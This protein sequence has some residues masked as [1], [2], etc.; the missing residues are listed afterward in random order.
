MARTFVLLAT[1]LPLLSA[2]A[3]ERDYGAARQKMVETIEGLATRIGAPHGTD[4]LAPA[5]LAAMR[6]VPRHEF[7]PADVQGHSL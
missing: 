5:V 1:A 3:T 6:Q 7:V 2:A 4:R